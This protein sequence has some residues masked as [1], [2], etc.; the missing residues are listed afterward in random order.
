MLAMAFKRKRTLKSICSEI[1]S[2]EMTGKDT[3]PGQILSH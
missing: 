1:P 3:K 2:K